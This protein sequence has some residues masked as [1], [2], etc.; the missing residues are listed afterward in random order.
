MV[1][2]IYIEQVDC[3]KQVKLHVQFNTF[4]LLVQTILKYIFRIIW[5]INIIY[6]HTPVQI[7]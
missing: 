2:A 6:T 1:N 7:N 3:M 5:Y 4:L